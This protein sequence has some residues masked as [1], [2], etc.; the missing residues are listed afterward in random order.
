MCRVSFGDVV[1]VIKVPAILEN[2]AAAA[3]ALNGVQEAA[4]SSGDGVCTQ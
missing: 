3:L 1:V 2:A 4:S